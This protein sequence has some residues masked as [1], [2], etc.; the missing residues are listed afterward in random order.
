M[1]FLW[2]PGKRSLPAFCWTSLRFRITGFLLTKRLFFLKVI[3]YFIR[4]LRTYRVCRRIRPDIAL[5]VGDFYLPQVGRLLG[6]PA[7]VI[8]DTE[9]VV[10]DAFLTFPFATKILTPAC[11]QR[12]LGKNRSG[13]T[14]IMLWPTC[15]P[16][17]LRLI[18]GRWGLWV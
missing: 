13:M 7:I 10:H 8:T 2:L 9:P 3:D 6:F 11:Y 17:I 15:I 18:R 5:G 14:T 16:N 4:W 1:K 12:A